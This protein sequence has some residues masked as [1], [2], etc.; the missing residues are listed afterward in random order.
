MLI[1]HLFSSVFWKVLY[2]MLAGGGKQMLT[3][4]AAFPIPGKLSRPGVCQEPGV[5]PG[6]Q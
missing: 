4:K 5:L 6:R 3:G 2:E 1:S